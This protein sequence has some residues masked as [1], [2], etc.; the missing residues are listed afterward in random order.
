MALS[1]TIDNKHSK[2][3]ALEKKVVTSGNWYPSEGTD[4]SIHYF[5]AA[6]NF[7]YF[8]GYGADLDFFCLLD[9]NLGN[10]AGGDNIRPVRVNNCSRSDYPFVYKMLHLL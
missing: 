9:N 3:K 1:D 5:H 2:I 6:R 7:G 10:F 4:S 8:A